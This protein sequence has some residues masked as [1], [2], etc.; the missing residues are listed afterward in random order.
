MRYTSSFFGADK[1]MSKYGGTNK[2]KFTKIK[3][4]THALCCYMYLLHVYTHV[5]I[6]IFK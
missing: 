5:S 2:I 6:G 1:C 3:P 4:R